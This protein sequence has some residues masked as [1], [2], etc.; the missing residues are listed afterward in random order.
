MAV[1]RAGRN[2]DR[3]PAIPRRCGCVRS[4]ACG[5]RS[6]RLLDALDSV[7][8]LLAR[9]VAIGRVDSMPGQERVRHPVQRR[10]QLRI[11]AQED[12]LHL[13]LRYPVDAGLRVDLGPEVAREETVRLE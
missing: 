4:W 5:Y 1:D 12:V 3:P 11:V 13:R 10:L 7:L 9:A 8:D 2:G 6:Q